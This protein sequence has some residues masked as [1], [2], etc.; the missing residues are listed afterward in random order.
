MATTSDIPNTGL[1]TTESNID[2]QSYIT[3]NAFKTNASMITKQSYTQETGLENYGSM[4]SNQS[5]ILKTELRK[6]H[7]QLA[8]V[9]SPI[10]IL[11]IITAII[12]CPRNSNNLRNQ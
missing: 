6:T 2:N 3:Y 8:I 7:N 1:L 11:I 4:I 5:Y 9:I 10:A 12:Y